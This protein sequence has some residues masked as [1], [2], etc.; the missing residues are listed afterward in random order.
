MNI[1]D[2][3]GKVRNMQDDMKKMREEL[4]NTIVEGE[5]G[6]GMVKVTMSGDNKLRKVEVDDSIMSDKTMMQDLIVAAV[7]NAFEKVQEKLNENMKNI[8]SGIPN[9]PG[10]DLFK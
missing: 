1:A 10:M 5:S 3:I 9:I 6:A 7:N 8:Q 4:E 2:M